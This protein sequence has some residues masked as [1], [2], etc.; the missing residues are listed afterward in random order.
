MHIAARKGL[1]SVT[2]LLIEKG[3][4]VLAVD[5]QGL[6]PALSCAPNKN[7]AHCLNIILSSYPPQTGS[8]IH[9]GMF[10]KKKFLSFGIIFYGKFY[11]FFRTE[12]ARK[13][14]SI[15]TAIVADID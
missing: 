1:V 15:S 5:S 14:H 13:C 2:Q 11:I 3:A 7:V 6:T 8:V 10:K 12:K 4:D 9:K